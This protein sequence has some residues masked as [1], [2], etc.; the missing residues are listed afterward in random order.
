MQFES[1]ASRPGFLPPNPEVDGRGVGAECQGNDVDAREFHVGRVAGVYG[2][3]YKDR[4][5]L[6]MLFSVADIR[7][8]V[9]VKRGGTG[10]IYSSRGAGSPGTPVAP[11]LVTQWGILPVLYGGLTECN[12]EM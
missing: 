5:A 4:N 3:E 12:Q 6:I 1:G 2:S 7:F 9:V 8:L 10:I 11:K